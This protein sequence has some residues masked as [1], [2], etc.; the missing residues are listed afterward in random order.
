MG[1]HIWN[2]NPKNAGRSLLFNDGDHLWEMACEYFEWATENPLIEQ[3]PMS[4]AGELVMAK[5]E[6]PRAF[7]FSGLCLYL[8]IASATYKRWRADDRFKDA[9]DR[10]DAVIYTQ[11]FEGAAVGLFN[12]WIVSRD[13]GLA[14]ESIDAE[15]KKLQ[16][17]KLQKELSPPKIDAPE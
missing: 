14:N 9:C 10:I 6:K 17:E 5:I 2:K 12:P 8:E 13:L 3:K 7:T 4:I 11:K 1:K 15:I 16:L